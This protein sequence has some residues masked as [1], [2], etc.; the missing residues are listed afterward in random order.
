MLL[1]VLLP[2]EAS[3]TASADTA[4][5]LVASASP[6]ATPEDFDVEFLNTSEMRRSGNERKEEAARVFLWSYHCSILGVRRKD[7]CVV[8]KAV[9]DLH[10]DNDQCH[11]LGAIAIRGFR[12][13][14]QCLEKIAQIEGTWQDLW[15]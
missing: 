1:R 7:R 12:V 11:R 14:S 3:L 4:R 8:A 13:L 6:Q 10:G 2:F 15:W 5:V 9:D